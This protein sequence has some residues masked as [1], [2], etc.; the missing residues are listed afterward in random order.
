MCL[1]LNCWRIPPKN[2]L[3]SLHFYSKAPYDLATVVSPA[4]TRQLFLS[5]K[6]CIVFFSKIIERFFKDILLLWPNFN[7]YCFFWPKFY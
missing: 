5:S 4:S 7:D 1:T 6:K 2:V 3:F